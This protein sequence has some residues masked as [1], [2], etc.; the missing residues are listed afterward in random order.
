L[1]SKCPRLRGRKLKKIEFEDKLIRKLD[2]IA[3]KIDAL[4]QLVAF[5][6]QGK[7]ILKGKTK[8]KQIEILARF[9]L[10]RDIIALLVGT[11][12]ETVSVRI[13]EMK[14]KQKAERK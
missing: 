1:E 6:A 11:T 2:E 4:I 5:I 3:T 9:G 14:K 8:T 10:R 12:P 7:N 13:S